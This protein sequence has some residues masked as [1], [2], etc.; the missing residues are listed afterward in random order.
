MKWFEKLWDFGAKHQ[1]KVWFIAATGF[2]LL[3][4]Q[5]I[6][7]LD[8]EDF[9]GLTL[10]GKIGFILFLT[11]MGIGALVTFIQ[12]VWLRYRQVKKVIKDMARK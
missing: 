4:I 11:G 2:V 9:Q 1:R 3:V 6:I 7:S 12:S 5:A 10:I 8:F